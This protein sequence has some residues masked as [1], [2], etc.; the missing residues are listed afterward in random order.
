MNDAAGRSNIAKRASHRRRE[1]G[2]TADKLLW[3]ER[4]TS[5]KAS[6]RET[7]S[8]KAHSGMTPAS[9]IFI[10]ILEKTGADKMRGSAIL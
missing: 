1:E 8:E 6:G 5:C 9:F 3:R 7:M 2:V 4:F 10:P